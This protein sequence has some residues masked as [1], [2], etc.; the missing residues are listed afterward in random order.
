MNILIIFA[1]MEGQ[2]EKIANSIADTVHQKG[3]Q[4]TTLPCKQVPAGFDTDSFDAVILGG[5]IHMG[6]YPGELHKFVTNHRDWLNRVPSALFTVCM[7]INSINEKDQAAAR[8]YS[9]KFSLDTNWQPDVMETFAGAVRYTQ[10]GFITRFIM[11]SIAKKE[12]RDTDT[13]R[14]YEY[15]DWKKVARFT[16]QFL[17]K[18]GELAET[19]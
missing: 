14:D 5:P 13:S 6:K 16:E 7:A 17:T 3:H 1:T 2:T 9:E 11:R 15:T 4:P 19:G 12:G 18:I 8:A 10:Y